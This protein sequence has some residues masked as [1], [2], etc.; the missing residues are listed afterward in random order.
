LI[1]TLSLILGRALCGRALLPCLVLS[2]GG[3]VGKC[4]AVVVGVQQDASMA[5][6]Q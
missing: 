4:L 1:G 3:I 2:S 6:R 5:A